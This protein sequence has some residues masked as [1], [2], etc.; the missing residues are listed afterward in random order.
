MSSDDNPFK[1]PSVIPAAE[2]AHRKESR[3][4]DDDSATI[5]RYAQL[6][7]RLLGVMWLVDGIGGIVG[8]LVYVTWQRAEIRRSGYEPTLDEYA[9]G[10]FAASAVILLAGIYFIVG[11]RWFLEKVFLPSSRARDQYN[12]EIDPP[13]D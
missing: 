1:P 3:L 10:W 6:G 9:L 2:S 13:G 5:A 12:N 8:S 7:L 4:I 11:G